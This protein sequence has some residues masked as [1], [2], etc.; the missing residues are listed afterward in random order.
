MAERYCSVAMACSTWRRALADVLEDAA[1]ETLRRRIVLFLRG[2][3]V[4]VVEN[5][6]GFVQ[7]RNPAEMRIDSW[8]VV[9]ILA[10]VNA[11]GFEFL[12][13]RVDVGHG[14]ALRILD[15]SAV[16]I[17][18]QGAREAK[19]DESVEI[20]GVPLGRRPLR[21]RTPQTQARAQARPQQSRIS[22]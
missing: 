13:G 22:A 1:L 18:D 6:A 16:G 11:G 9:E 14:L 15:S 7:P 2:F 17:R 20:V 21:S 19:I 3:V 5:L 4:R 10:V 8:M 12:D